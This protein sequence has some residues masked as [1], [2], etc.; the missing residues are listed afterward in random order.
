MRGALF[1]LWRKETVKPFSKRLADDLKT[2]RKDRRISQK[3]MAEQLGT[4]QPTIVDIEHGRSIPRREVLDR[5]Y[6]LL[7][8][9]EVSAAR[10]DAAPYHKE[11]SF[12]QWAKEILGDD[13]PYEDLVRLL[14]DAAEIE[15]SRMKRA[16]QQTDSKKNS[17]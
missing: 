14:R 16:N 2:Y 17:A 6:A 4:T 3:E 13:I 8:D 7:Y 10:E 12:V 9:K 15:L 5:L 1:R 11:K